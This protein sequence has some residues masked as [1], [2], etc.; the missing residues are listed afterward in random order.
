MPVI[1]CLPVVDIL[2][3]IDMRYNKR[4]YDTYNSGWIS[5][6][7]HFYESIQSNSRFKESF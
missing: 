3:I 6:M 5:I 2:W 7:T 4:S 1:I